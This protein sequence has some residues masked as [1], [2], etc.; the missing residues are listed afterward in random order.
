MCAVQCII[1]RQA[2]ENS[3][4]AVHGM[5][6][7]VRESARVCVC[8]CVCVARTCASTGSFKRRQA[9]EKL[10]YQC[11]MLCYFRKEQ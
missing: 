8:V 4:S 9:V 1:R 7:N 2:V 11:E 10:T 5:Q 6:R 3:S